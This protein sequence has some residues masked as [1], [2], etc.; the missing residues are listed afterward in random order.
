LHAI[1]G[2]PPIVAIVDSVQGMAGHLYETYP[3]SQ[4]FLH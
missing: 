2:S 1:T 3:D 4:E